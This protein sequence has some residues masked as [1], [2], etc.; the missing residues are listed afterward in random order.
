VDVPA[1][2]KWKIKPVASSLFLP[3]PLRFVKDKK[4]GEN[5]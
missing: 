1:F 3:R 5:P 2:G 4:Q